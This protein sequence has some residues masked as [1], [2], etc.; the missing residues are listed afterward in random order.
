[1]EP[2]DIILKLIDNEI[3]TSLC[4]LGRA[5]CKLSESI[6]NLSVIKHYGRRH[7]RNEELYLSNIDNRNQA[8]KDIKRYELTVR[9]LELVKEH[10]LEKFIYDE[11]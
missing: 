3:Q 4:L 11:V 1:M 9:E 7:G 10:A 5:T 8:R 2:E 6:A